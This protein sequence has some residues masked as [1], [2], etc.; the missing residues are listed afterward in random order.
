MSALV[1]T[2]TVPRGAVGV[3]ELT[4]GSKY[5]HINYSPSRLIDFLQKPAKRENCRTLKNKVRRNFW[6]TPKTQ[7]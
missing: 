6:G 4:V 1:K 3:T 5:A 2:C 7:K